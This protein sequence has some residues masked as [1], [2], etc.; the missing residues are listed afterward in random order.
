MMG[1]N[2]HCFWF[3]L[4]KVMEWWGLVNIDRETRK[5]FDAYKQT[6]LP[7]AAQKITA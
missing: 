2:V 7:T 3:H 5:A 1:H 4:R 6:D